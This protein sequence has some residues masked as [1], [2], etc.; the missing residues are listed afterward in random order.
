MKKLIAA[1]LLTATPAMAL[2]LGAMSE[3]EKEE[4]GAAIR[5]YLIANPEVLIESMNAL[6]QRRIADEARNDTA[7]IEQMKAE[8]YDY[9][10][11]WAGGNLEGDVTVVE[12]IDYRCGVCRQAFQDVEDTVSSDGNVKLIL[13]D[14]PILGPESEMASRFAIAVQ[15]AHGN[16]AYKQV[17]DTFYTMRGNVSVESLKAMAE[18]MGYDADALIE[19]MNTEAVTDV[20]RENAKLAN[21]LQISGTPTFIIGDQLLRGMPRTGIAPL[22]EAA[23]EAAKSDG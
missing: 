11:H 9:D 19:A 7:M 21:A 20:L 5:E 17:H 23:R 15:Q 10:G 14:Y 2:D 13:K 22:V 4:F 1:L 18:E 3:S 6:E 16:D 12:F 8:I